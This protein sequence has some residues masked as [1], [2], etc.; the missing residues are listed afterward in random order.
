MNQS[1]LS[2]IVR[3]ALIAIDAKARYDRAEPLTPGFPDASF[4]TPR[5]H[6]HGF[7]ELKTA[8]CPVRGTSQLPKNAVLNTH[9][10]DWFRLANQANAPA[11]VVIGL[12]DPQKN[13]W[14]GKA[15]ARRHATFLVVPAWAYTWFENQTSMAE[16]VTSFGRPRSKLGASIITACY[17][18]RRNRAW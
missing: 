13:L 8:K 1:A 18:G 9:Q 12:S 6:K 14:V 15:S 11:C 3:A 10:L 7:I 17:P 4:L 2:K 5:L 16:W